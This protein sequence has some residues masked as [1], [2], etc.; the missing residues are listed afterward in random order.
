M[1]NKTPCYITITPDQISSFIQQYQNM[2]DEINDN[3]VT[4]NLTNKMI[5]KL[6]KDNRVISIRN[7]KEIPTGPAV[8]LE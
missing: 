7:H 1:K 2:I 4:M 8:V 6:N 3:E 5:S